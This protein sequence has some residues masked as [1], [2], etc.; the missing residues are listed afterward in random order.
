MALSK[1]LFSVMPPT[2]MS[3]RLRTGMR[4]LPDPQADSRKAGRRYVLTLSGRVPAS[5][6]Q[7]PGWRR[8]LHGRLYVL[9]RGGPPFSLGPSPAITGRFRRTAQLLD[10]VGQAPVR[11]DLRGSDNR[12][13]RLSLSRLLEMWPWIDRTASPAPPVDAA[14]LQPDN[15]ADTRHID[16]GLVSAWLDDP[17]LAQERERLQRLQ[18][19]RRAAPGPC[20][21][22]Q[23][24]GRLWERFSR[25]LSRLRPWCAAC[26]IRH[27][28]IYGKAK[29]L[30]GYGLGR[31]EG[32]PD[33]QTIDD[34]A[35]DTVVAALIYFRDKGA[36]EPPLAKPREVR[37]WAPSS[38]ASASTSSPTS[39]AAPCEPNSNAS[40]RPPR[41]WPS[42]PKTGSTSS[43]ASK[44][45]SLPTTRFARRWRC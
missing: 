8:P 13:D 25:E 41:R 5:P 22:A 43:R 4:K 17:D 45:P 18:S 29:A 34:I 3:F 37:R 21:C 15:Q 24:T 1:S 30:T 44:R 42:Y 6:R 12:R 40:T 11:A 9:Q 16:N 2:V 35:T 28:T 39:T 10:N 33:D 36:H 23:F 14:R 7:S 27:G 20:S 38:S 19:R 32:W 31:I 26:W